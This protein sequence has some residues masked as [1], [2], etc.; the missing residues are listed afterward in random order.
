MRHVVLEALEVILQHRGHLVPALSG[1]SHEFLIKPVVQVLRHPRVLTHRSKR[2]LHGETC[3][4]RVGHVTGRLGVIMDSRLDGDLQFGLRALSLHT[5]LGLHLVNQLPMPVQLFQ[6]RGTAVNQLV[7]HLPG[8]PKRR[9]KLG[10]AVGMLR[11]HLI[12]VM[13]KIEKTTLIQEAVSIQAGSASEIRFLPRYGKQWKF[14][15]KAL[16]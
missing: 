4:H 9:S 7:Q 8:D 2:R 6:T 12:N 3:I 13:L 5:A 11:H 16:L 15:A 14:A 10:Q 1:A